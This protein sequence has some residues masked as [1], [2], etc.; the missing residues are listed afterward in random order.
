MISM[1]VFQICEI[2]INLD[3]EVKAILPKDIAW[4]QIRGIR[5]RFAHGYA[6]MS[7]GDIWAVVQTEI[8][9]LRSIFND[10]LNKME[11]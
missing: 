10:Y 3:E 11:N 8:P 7:I 2:M 9:K 6:E 4:N 1:F 5:N